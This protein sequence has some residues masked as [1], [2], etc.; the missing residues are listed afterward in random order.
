MAISIYLYCRL[1]QGQIQDFLKVG[2]NLQRGFDLLTV[3]D[4]LLFFPDFSEHS[5][6][7]MVV[8]C[9]KGGGGGGGG[10]VNESLEPH[11]DLLLLRGLIQ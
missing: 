10:G 2:S 7:K 9:L 8:F 3:P 5:P 4:Y 1:S 11:L 6:M